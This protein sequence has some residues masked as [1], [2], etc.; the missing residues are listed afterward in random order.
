[1]NLN[2]Q[3]MAINMLS[4]SPVIAN[5]PNTQQYLAIIRSGDASKG[6]QIAENLCRSYG[7]RKDDAVAMAK[8]FF[9]L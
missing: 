3:Q 7:V 4:N 6:A 5:N 1:M 2:L 9:K 8:K